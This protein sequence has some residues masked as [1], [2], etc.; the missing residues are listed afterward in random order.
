MQQLQPHAIFPIVWV[1]ENPFDTDTYYVRAV[2]RNSR[3]GATITTLTLTDNG[4]RRFTYN[5]TTPSDSSGQG[6][7]IDITILIYTDAAFTTKSESYAEKNTQYLVI[8]RNVT[9]QTL[10]SYLAGTLGGGDDV[11]YKRIRKIFEDVLSE[12]PKIE[13]QTIDLSSVNLAFES[14]QNIVLRL[15]RKE[16]VPT[17]LSPIMQKL[18]EISTLFGAKQAPEKTPEKAPEKTDFSLVLDAIS[19]IN[20][21]DLKKALAELEIMIAKQGEILLKRLEVLENKQEKPVEI[22]EQ[23]K[24]ILSYIDR[25]RLVN[26]PGL[27]RFKYKK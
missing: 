15:E 12:K 10:A 13:M 18:T 22:I 23:K 14:L 6:L 2:V 25:M 5:Y 4:S 24:P 26:D 8:D 3:T 20:N 17:D 16:A 19:K 9:A 7:Y 11:D 21:D 27:K 1:Q